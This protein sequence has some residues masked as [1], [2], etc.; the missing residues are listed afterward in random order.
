MTR[1]PPRSWLFVLLL[2]ALLDAC[3][4]GH[5]TPLAEIGA[6]YREDVDQRMQVY[7]IK[8]GDVLRVEI[9]T[10]EQR[11]F[12]QAEV[13]VRPDG[14][15]DL[16][17]LPDFAMAGKTVEEVRSE[18]SERV[19]AQIRDAEVSIQVTSSGEKVYLVGQFER[20]GP[21]EL[22]PRMTLA[23]AISAGGGY[24]ITGDT[25]DAVLRRPYRDP[26]HPDTYSIDLEEG[27]Q[28]YLLPG[29]Q[30]VLGRTWMASFVHYLQEYVFFM[31]DFRIVYGIDP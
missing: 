8:P 30:V 6:A 3:A 21:L 1:M 20:P 11:N 10:Q 28:L 31:F 25:D 4:F 22:V 7:R 2:S 5:V 12:S 19:R 18:F 29:D 17:F 23:E 24:L 13:K 27:G 16:Y 9:S 14:H 15:A 26:E